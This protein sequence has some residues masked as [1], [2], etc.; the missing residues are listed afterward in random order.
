[1]KN[2]LIALDID[3]TL[4]SDLHSLPGEVELCLER[5]ASSGATVVLVT[6]RCFSLAYPPLKNWNFPYLLAIHNGAVILRMPEKKIISKQYIDPGVLAELDRIVSV[7]E[8]DYALYT[9]IENSDIC[10]YRPERFSTRLCEYVRMRANLC[11]ENWEAVEDFG[12]SSINTLTAIKFF[13][14]RESAL[15]IQAKV[16]SKL[17]LHIPVITDPI[18]H[19][20]Y[21]AQATHPRIDKG[22]AVERILNGEN[23]PVIAAGDDYNDLP[24]LNKADVKIVMATAPEEIRKIADIVAQPASE[25]GIIEAMENAW[26]NWI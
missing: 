18:N 26:N 19:S 3:G 8:T 9:G 12:S 22:S 2:P 17:S 7:E 15:R 4:T 24:M 5:L 6:G 25:K 1:M 16:E 21:I 11:G 20:V 13:G 23:P 10:Y 14:N